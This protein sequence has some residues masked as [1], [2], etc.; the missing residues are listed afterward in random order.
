MK[1]YRKI[2][3]KIFKINRKI[4][5]IA[6]I[7]SSMKIRRTIMLKMG[8]RTTVSKV[9]RIIGNTRIR[10]IRIHLMGS[11]IHMA[12]TET[13]MRILII[14]TVRDRI[15]SIGRIS[16]MEIKINNK[17]SQICRLNHLK[18][19]KDLRCSFGL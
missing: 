19:V 3:T 9:R 18:K 13:R 16:S 14:L 4:R 17:I 1:V 15:S 2:L 12:N 7:M 10:K 6:Q 8:I 5:T 11:T